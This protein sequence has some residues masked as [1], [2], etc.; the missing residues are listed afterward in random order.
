MIMDTRAQFADAVSIAAAAG[1]ALIGSQYDLGQTTPYTDVDDLY[2]VIMVSTAIITGGSAGKVR[3]QLAS[4]STAAI[5]VDGSATVHYQTGDFV[6]GATPI[7]VGSVLAVIEL[8]KGNGVLPAY[9]R[10]LGILCVTTTT[11]TT[12]GAIRAF[13][14][15]D[16]GRWAALPQ[17]VN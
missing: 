11:T 15:P 2:L 14:T 12:T 10:Y 1:T 4:D 3:F 16:G 6:T 7:A 9:E 13:L 5:A 8:P 17:A